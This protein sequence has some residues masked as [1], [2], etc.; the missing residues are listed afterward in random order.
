[1]TPTRDRPLPTNTPVTHE[2][3]PAKV[4]WHEIVNLSILCDKPWPET[5]QGGIGSI[6]SYYQGQL[7][8]YMGTMFE[9]GIFAI[10]VINCEPTSGKPGYPKSPVWLY[11][12]PFKPK[13]YNK[14]TF[15]F[16]LDLSTTYMALEVPGLNIF[17]PNFALFPWSHTGEPPAPPLYIRTGPECS[18]DCISDGVLNIDDF[19]CYQT[20]FALGDLKAD[21][22]ADGVLLID[23]FICFQTAFVLGC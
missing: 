9:W 15:T 7:Y 22:D 11:A 1:M 18:A 16:T 14:E 20:L 13:Q 10:H 21:C 3:Y 23:D 17:S 4:L 2:V 8:E 12:F 19:I 6:T 5:Y